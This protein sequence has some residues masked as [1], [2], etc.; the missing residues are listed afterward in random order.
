M[1][2]IQKFIET[3]EVGNNMHSVLLMQGD[4]VLFEGY[5]EPYNEASIQRMYSE[6][7]SLVGIAIGML[8]Y[9]GKLSIDDPICKYFP[10]RI[11]RQLPELLKQQTIR[12]NLMMSTAVSYPNWFVDEDRDRVHLYFNKSVITKAPGTI[13]EYDSTGSEVLGCLVEKLSGMSLLEYIQSKTGLFKTAKILKVQTGESWC[14]SGLLST[15]REMAQFGRF[16]MNG[17]IGP[18]GKPTVSREYLKAAT[19]NLV[20]TNELGF[21]SYKALGYGYQI[22]HTL[23]DGFCFFGMGNQL[24]I[25]IPSKDFLFACTA[26]DQGYAESR[27]VLMDALYKYIVGKLDEPT[28]LSYKPKL[29]LKHAVGEKTAKIVDSINNVKF[30]AADNKMGIKWFSLSFE[31][32]RLTFNYENAQGIKKMVAGACFNVFDKFPEWGY[33]KETGGM[34]EPGHQYDAAFSYAFESDHN[35]LIQ[36]RII[37]DYLGNLSIS[38]GF[39]GD[40]ATVRFIKSAED[41]LR[42]YEGTMICKKN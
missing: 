22:W 8:E 33:S 13:F 6:T 38:F 30:E 25:C 11:D 9:E 31:G 41:F 14:D 26:D 27:R 42:E 24:T 40:Y 4:K 20:S 23:D 36:C 17:C 12:N 34:R 16:V 21:F 2:D 10:E 18:D 35:L 1:A 19:S 3:I 32:D 37:D 28:D 7:K 5:W 39:D 15:L 29:M